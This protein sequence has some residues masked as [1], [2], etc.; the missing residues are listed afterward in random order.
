MPNKRL[1]DVGLYDAVL[2]KDNHIAA[3]GGLS[4]ALRAIRSAPSSPWLNGP[5]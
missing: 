3:A 5:T 1:P 2:I 4:L